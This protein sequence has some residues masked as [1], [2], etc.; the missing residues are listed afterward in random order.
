[1]NTLVNFRPAQP[2]KTDQFS[3]GANSLTALTLNIANAQTITYPNRPVRMIVP[4]TPAGPID[5]QAR[6]LAE[7]LTTAFGRQVIV[8]NRAGASG[9]IGLSNVA[10]ASADGHTLAFASQAHLA[11]HPSLHKLPYDIEKDFSPIILMGHVRYLLLTHPSVGANNLKELLALLRSKPGHYNF[12]SVSSGSNSHIIG[13]L[14]K[15]TAK[16]NIVH[17]PYRGAGPAYV[18]LVSGESHLMFASPVAV[19]H[20]V[21]NGQLKAIAIAAGLRSDQFPELPTMNEAGLPGFESAGWLAL[22]TRSGVTSSIIT[23]LNAEVNRFLKLPQIRERLSTMDVDPAGGSV[24]D[25]TAHIHSERAKWATVI[26]EAG[27][28]IQ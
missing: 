2:S 20:Y 11:L 12:A 28:K 18:G 13:E 9:I 8:D 22:I 24:N 17:I 5:V 19:T 3:A 26:K 16:V 6:L 15:R 21:R 10:S 7:H 14:F 1:M 25:V 4:T 27:I 23:K